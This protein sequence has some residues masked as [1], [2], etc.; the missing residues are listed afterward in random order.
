MRPSSAISVSM[1]VGRQLGVGNAEV[2]GELAMATAH[3]ERAAGARRQ[4]CFLDEIR[5]NL[6]INITQGLTSF[7][8]LVRP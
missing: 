6:L 2:D 3:V 5:P 4:S 7:P 8:K 1:L